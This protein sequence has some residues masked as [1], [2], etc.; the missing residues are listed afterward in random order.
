[1]VLG[2]FE[3]FNI[4]NNLHFNLIMKL[5]NVNFLKLFP[6]SCLVLFVSLE[7]SVELSSENRVKVRELSSDHSSSKVIDFFFNLS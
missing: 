2:L 3:E 7:E 5:V 1:M 6:I 4:L